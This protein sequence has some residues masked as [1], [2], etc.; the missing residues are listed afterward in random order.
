MA[1]MGLNVQMSNTRKLRKILQIKKGLASKTLFKKMNLPFMDFFL[2]DHAQY[3]IWDRSVDLELV[4]KVVSKLNSKVKKKTVVI[5]TPSF[6]GNHAPAK[7]KSDCF[8]L[9]CDDKE[10]ITTFWCSDPDYLFAKEGTT[11]NFRLLY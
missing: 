4:D 7:S 2:T 8:I 3:R 1:T 9:I 6:V 10:I 11:S 5:A